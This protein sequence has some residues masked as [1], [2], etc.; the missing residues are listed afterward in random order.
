MAANYIFE[1]DA[2][3]QISSDPDNP[4]GQIAPHDIIWKSLAEQAGVDTKPVLVYDYVAG[5]STYREAENPAF[6]NYKNNLK[7]Q[8]YNVG[9]QPTPGKKYYS[10]FTI[11]GP[12]GNPVSDTITVKTSQSAWDSFKEG[13]LTISP[14][15]I[16]GLT[17]GMGS[18][19]ASALEVSQPV[20]AGLISGG[21]TAVGGG[22]IGDIAKAGLTSAAGSY[23]M[24]ALAGGDS[25]LTPEMQATISSNPQ[26][27]FLG[28]SAIPYPVTSPTVTPSVLPAIDPFVD[29]VVDQIGNV[30]SGSTGEVLIPA[31]E[32]AAT[33]AGVNA[34]ADS[35]TGVDMS[36]NVVNAL[37][38]EV[39][40]PAGGASG[41]PFVAGGTVDTTGNAGFS[42]IENELA[43]LAQLEAGQATPGAA[44]PG[45]ETA[46][47]GGQ[48]GVNAYL[49]VA[50]QMANADVAARTDTG[51]TQQ[52]GTQQTG[53][54]GTTLGVSDALWGPIIGSIAAL[55]GGSQA[56]SAASE[57]AQ[58]QAA[59]LDRATQLQRDIYEKGIALQEPFYLGGKEAFNRLTALSTGGPEAAQNFLTMDPGYGFRLGEGMKALERLQASRGNLLSGGAIKAGQRY[60]QDVASQE[61]GSAYNRLAQL[62]DVGPRAAGVTS[63]LGQ[64]YA[65]SAGGLM[66]QSGV[67]SANA[68]LT[69][70]AAR[71]SAYGD[72]GN[73]WGRYFGGGK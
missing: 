72:V 11:I 48:A 65:T 33:G 64:N 50:E 25:L 24:N 7:A 67:N 38:G 34:L 5:E 63:Q 4:S 12:D 44:L 52:T 45:I 17:A 54:G 66:G 57:A 19:L 46:L 29:A 49:G 43:G 13:I 71:Q 15:I 73:I 47:A 70:A 36:G 62:A 68:L 69:G 30:I 16:S 6:T 61:Y 37:T 2:R 32:A 23:A 41:T 1:D 35:M 8:G 22:D 14:A 9:F 18:S 26:G 3:Y 59:A 40:A 10:D 31:Q 39:V 56:A 20:A 58:T 27:A 21:V 51:A 60:A 42:T 55:Y 53:T 28:E